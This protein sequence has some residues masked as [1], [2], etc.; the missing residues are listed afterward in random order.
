MSRFQMFPLLQWVV[1]V[2]V[3]FYPM[4]L[5][6]PCYLA[7]TWLQRWMQ[8]QNNIGPVFK[9]WSEYQTKFSP[10][11]KWHSNN[12]SFSD[13]TTIDHLKTRLV[14]YSGPHGSYVFYIE[15]W[16]YSAPESFLR[17]FS[18]EK[19]NESWVIRLLDPLN[20]PVTQL[21]EKIHELV[22]SRHRAQVSNDQNPNLWMVTELKNVD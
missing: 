17:S 8:Y 7:G 12:G 13:R 5:P 2:W 9:W 16:L 10:V 6:Y 15:W 4:L 14:R 11:L 1:R 21:G 18:G 19:V 3:F 20:L 22:L